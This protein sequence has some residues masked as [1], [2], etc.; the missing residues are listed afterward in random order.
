MYGSQ[1]EEITISGDDM[2]RWV[3]DVSESRRNKTLRFPP[4]NCS[5]G[6]LTRA[7]DAAGL[8]GGGLK[9]LKND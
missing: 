5:P 2:Q 6:R 1:E 3:L 8:N 4:G 7:S 9:H